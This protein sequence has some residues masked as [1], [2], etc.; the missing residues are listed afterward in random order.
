MNAPPSIAYV[1]SRP[2]PSTEANGAAVM[3]MCAALAAAGAQV[4]LTSFGREGEDPFSA[5]GLPDTFP[6]RRLAPRG[7]PLAYPLLLRAGLRGRSRRTLVYTRIPQVAAYACL[8]GR[9][10]VLEMHYPIGELRRGR[11]SLRILNRLPGRIA[12]VVAVNHALAAELRTELHGYRGE[13]LVAPSAAPDFSV[14]REGPPEFDVGFVGSFHKGRGTHLVLELAARFPQAR[15][16]MVGGPASP[17]L[18]KAATLL[19][20][21]VLKGAILHAEVAAMLAS[22]EIALA[23]YNDRI[24]FANSPLNIGRWISPMKIVEYMSAAKPIVASALPAVG[25]LVEDGVTALLAPPDDIE[26]WSEVVGRLLADAGLR[27]R[28]GRA[29]RR[30]FET[31][32]SWSDRAHAVLSYLG[33]ET[34]SS[35]MDGAA[36]AS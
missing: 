3:H 19:P 20:N 35:G 2:I 25:E 7:G 4:G 1:H 29:A 11:A 9:R 16:V 34:A 23:P 15:F 27:R 28:L 14:T 21:L 32:L 6:V 17:E 24:H 31:G 12:G 33:G 26:G 10:T 18:A 30:R 8:A 36:P 22:F 13:I 5:Y